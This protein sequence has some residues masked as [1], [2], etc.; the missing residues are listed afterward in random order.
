MILRTVIKSPE[1]SDKVDA[2][3]GIY[4]RLE[5]A[6]NA[7]KWW[8]SHDPESGELIDDYHW[9]YKQRGFG[10]EN[11]YLSGTLYF[12]CRLRRDYGPLG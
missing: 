5:E 6:F 10:H 3:S 12:R 9:L 4:P 8:L 2:E 7:L 11:T 1:V